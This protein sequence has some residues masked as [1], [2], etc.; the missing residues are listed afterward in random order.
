MKI[1]FV[2]GLVMLGLGSAWAQPRAVDVIVTTATQQSIHSRHEALATVQAAESVRITSPVDDTVAR[3]AFEEG[4][5]VEA[6]QVLVELTQAQE[7]AA[8]QSAQARLAEARSALRRVEELQGQGLASEAKLD[9][10]R[11][12]ELAAAAAVQAAKAAL[13][14][15]SIRAPFAGVLGLREISPGAYLRAG[16]VITTLQDLSRLKLEF[17]LPEAWLDALGPGLQITATRPGGGPARPARLQA[18]ARHLDPATRSLRLRAVLE[19]ADDAPLPGSLMLVTLKSRP[20][21]ALM[22]PEAALIPNENRQA[23]Y[24]IKDKQA[25]LQSVTI[26]VRREGAVEITGGLDAGDTVVVH[27]GNKLRPG[28]TVRILAE[29]DGSVPIADLIRQQGS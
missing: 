2:A 23:V 5:Q 11:A 20:R 21:Q 22:L 8:L 1:V 29:Y 19:G 7:Q 4:Q 14:D 13:D 28:G 16:D 12:A 9:Q 3:I 18:K 26:G 15:R 24:R 6:G 25:E 27:G 10:A 17:T